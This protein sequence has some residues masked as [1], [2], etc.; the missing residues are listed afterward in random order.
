M[1]APSDRN[2]VDYYV[3][4]GLVF[5]GFVPGRPKD[6]IGVAAAIAGISERASDLDRDT[7]SFGTNTP[8]RNDE[9]L[10]EANYI[11]EI[12]PGWTFQPDFQYVWR[13]GGSV[14]SESGT[15]P[16]GDAAIIGARTTINY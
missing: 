7:V 5:A 15:K 6:T 4:G 9:I 11:A 13:P 1:G 16:L 2:L 14:P 10:M 3:D 12:V 8:V